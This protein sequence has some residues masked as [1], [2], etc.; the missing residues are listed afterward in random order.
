MLFIVRLGQKELKFEFA[1]EVIIIFVKSIK[2]ALRGMFT[3][4]ICQ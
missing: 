2:K 4:L 1:I 3:L